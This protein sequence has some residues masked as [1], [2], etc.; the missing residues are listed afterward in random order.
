[1]I[2][3]LIGHGP[4]RNQAIK[5]VKAALEA[6]KIVGVKTTIP[7]HL[8]ILSAERFQDGSYSTRFIPELLA[9]KGHDSHG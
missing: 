6:F 3:K 4:D 7:I 9:S 8:E 2:C 5:T 1:L